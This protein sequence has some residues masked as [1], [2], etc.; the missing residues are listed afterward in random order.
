MA[1]LFFAAPIAAS[2][3]IS[4]HCLHFILFLG[5]QLTAGGADF[6]HGCPRL[7]HLIMSEGAKN[8]QRNNTHS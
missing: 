5:L 4:D 1:V 2:I 8:G 3:D 7:L 6:K